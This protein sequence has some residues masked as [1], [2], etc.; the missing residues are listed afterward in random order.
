MNSALLLRQSI[1]QDVFDYQTL[2]EILGE[3]VSK[4]RDLAARLVREGSLVRIRRGLYI[5]GELLRK[6]TV[7]REY[8]S[9]LIYGPSYVSLDYALSFYSM[10]PEKVFTVTSVSLGRSREFTTPFGRFSYRMLGSDRYSTGISME[11]SGSIS[12]LVAS[13][14]KALIDKVWSDT[15]ATRSTS[16]RWLSYLEEDLR[17]DMDK[18]SDFS[19]GMLRGIADAYSSEKISSFTA[20]L[21][22]LIGEKR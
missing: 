2:T 14:E 18:L 21:T 10:I 4:P 5:F 20:F 17:L 13:P 9:N 11:S 3:R 15:R 22:D 7:S 12:F 6:H 8:L 19:P 1:A 16:R